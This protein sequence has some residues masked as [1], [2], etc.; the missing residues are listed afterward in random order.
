ML[1]DESLTYSSWTPFR[2]C[3]TQLLL[4][5]PAQTTLTDLT[6]DGLTTASQAKRADS[7]LHER[8]K[9]L[10]RPLLV[11][12]L[13]FETLRRRRCGTRP[14]RIETEE[15]KLWTNNLR[16]FTTRALEEACSG[17]TGTSWVKKDGAFVV[18]GVISR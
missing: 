7:R 16:D 2:R 9:R 13:R 3:A 5:V 18:G 11:L 1:Q 14:S 15:V 8:K 12:R 6:H 4:S 10:Q 17:T